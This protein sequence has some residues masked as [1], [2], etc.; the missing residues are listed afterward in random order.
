MELI[1]HQENV[2][3]L[4]VT[5]AIMDY[6]GC[7]NVKSVMISQGSVQ[8]GLFHSLK[9]HA[10]QNDGNIHETTIGLDYNQLDIDGIVSI[11][12]KINNTTILIESKSII[13]I[14]IITKII[15]IVV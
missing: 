14:I 7:N 1:N 12:K 10:Y 13:I 3:G 4:N 15:I 5:I 9:F 8:R 6:T 2:C 11:G